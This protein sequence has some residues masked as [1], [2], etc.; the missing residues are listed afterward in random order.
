MP[1]V[2]L[3][4]HHKD[5]ARWRRE[6]SLS[7]TASRRPDLIDAARAAGRLTKADEKFLANLDSGTL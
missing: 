7:L 6:Q 3:S 1:S 4:G 5:I 2:L